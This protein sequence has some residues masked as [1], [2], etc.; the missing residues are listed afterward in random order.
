M[1]YL[2][3][4]PLALEPLLAEVSAPYCGGTCAFLGT[5]RDGPGDGGVTAIEYS[6]YER[7]AEAELDRIVAETRRQWADAPG[8]A[9]RICFMTSETVAGRGTVRVPSLRPANSA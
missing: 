6:A 9:S 5:V 1:N 2:T 3:T 8:H 7:M 4:T